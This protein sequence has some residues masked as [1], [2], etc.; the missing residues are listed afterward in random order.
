VPFPPPRL[1]VL[2]VDDDPDVRETM[3]D[4]IEASGRQAFG[5]RDGT[6]ALQLLTGN[7]L[8]RP[9]AVLV[10]WVMAPMN[11]EQF[12]AQV[13]ARTDRAL[14]PVVLSTGSED[15]VPGDLGPPG[16]VRV[17]RKPFPLEELLDALEALE[18]IGLQSEP[19]QEK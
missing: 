1:A 2:V 8:P 11:G 5:A 13:R 18:R 7:A 10:D 15:L 19:G 12:V 14:L 6:E 16:V 4:A 17:L 3:V 9:C